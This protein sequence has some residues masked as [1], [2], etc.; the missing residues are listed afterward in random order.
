M[1]KTTIV[2]RV[3]HIA[4]LGVAVIGF[5]AAVLGWLNS[6]LVAGAPVGADLASFGGLL[7]G[8]GLG[9][10]L[11]WMALR[12]TTVSIKTTAALYG[13]WIADFAWY[14]FNRFA[15]SEIHTLD[16]EKMAHDQVQQTAIS[17]CI[18]LVWVG[19][20]LIGPILTARRLRH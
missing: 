9:G 14:W 10:V 11:L 18:F 16:P 6:H 17:V 15:V 3:L 5:G 1:L 8:A 13:G 7:L 2:F 19:L 12:S 4:A 20:Y